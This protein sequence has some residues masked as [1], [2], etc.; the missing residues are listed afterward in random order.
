MKNFFIHP[1]KLL[2]LLILIAVTSV[3]FAQDT[4][5]TLWVYDDGR[6]EVLTQLGEEF[7]AEYG[8]GLT[9]EVVD[10]SEIRNAM[11]LGAASGEGPDM[12][13][14]PHDNL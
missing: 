4:S 5:L 12:I 3:A 7:E 13:I 6:L 1:A 10:L 14:I 9:V 2:V 8:V 11:T